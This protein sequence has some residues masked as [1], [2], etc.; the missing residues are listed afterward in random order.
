MSNQNITQRMTQASG[1]G[2]MVSRCSLDSQLGRLDRHPTN[3]G[4]SLSRYTNGDLRKYTNQR[5]KRKAW[6]REDNQL[7]LHCYFRSNP[8]Q[9]GYRKRMMEIWQEHSNFQTTSQRL[10]D[11]VR[12]IIKKGWFSDL[13]IL[14]IHQKINDQQGS[15]NTLPGTSNINKLSPSEMN[16]QIRK[17]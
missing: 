9:R 6:T 13:E 7:A 3:A 12:T 1:S 14:E 8:T 11:Q 15:N 16:H 2:V 4:C 17:M 5:P 10:Y